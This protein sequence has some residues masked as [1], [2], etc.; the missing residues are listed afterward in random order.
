MVDPRCPQCSARV[1]ADAD[2]CS[3]CYTS[4]RAA[5][6]P[7]PAPAPSPA[8]SPPVAVAQRQ[9]PSYASAG[10]SSAYDPLNAPLAALAELAGTADAAVAAGTAG[11]AAAAWPCPT[12]DTAV[13]IERD[14]CPICGGRF[15]NGAAGEI[16]LPLVGSAHE[17]SPSKKAWIMVG[18]A[19]AVT[20]TF[21][22][23]ATVIGLIF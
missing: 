3:L 5:P 17:L 14:E 23:L 7:A 10:P 21:L 16:R 8:A 18:G 20:A 11:T 6:A 4:L 12:C 15:L 2:W 22:I 9:I 19:A 13:A 1:P